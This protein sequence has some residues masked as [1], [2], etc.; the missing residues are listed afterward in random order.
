LNKIRSLLKDFWLAEL[1][2]KLGFANECAG[3]FAVEFAEVSIRS[4]QGKRSYV[5]H[6]SLLW[7]V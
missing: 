5:A 6:D 4:L 3:E 2:A 1:N 7:Q